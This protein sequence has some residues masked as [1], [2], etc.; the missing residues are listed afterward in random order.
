MTTF[1]CASCPQTITVAELNRLIAASVLR[2]HGW[3]VERQKDGTVQRL[4]P[5][6][7][8]A[9]KRPAGYPQGTAADGEGEGA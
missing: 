2:H 6:C 8:A 3:L 1:R 7:L 4:C 5:A 9:R